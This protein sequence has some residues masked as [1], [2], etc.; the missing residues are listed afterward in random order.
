[1][2]L[3]A[4]LRFQFRV[5]GVSLAAL[6]LCAL[7][8]GAFG[9]AATLSR[10]APQFTPEEAALRV[11]AYTFL[12]GAVPVLVVF[13]P[14]Y[15]WFVRQ[16][17][18]GWL[19]AGVTGLLPGMLGAWLAPT[20]TVPALVLGLAVGLITHAACRRAVPPPQ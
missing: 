11:A 18:A 2:A 17:T 12:F 6:L 10:P 7:V 5:W 13:A 19:A 9:W 15:A 16:G 20:M 8:A 3:P 1:M 4:G 14:L